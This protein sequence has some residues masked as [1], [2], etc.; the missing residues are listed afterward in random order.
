VKVRQ[1]LVIETACVL[2]GHDTQDD[3]HSGERLPK[4]G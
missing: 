1:H 4:V 3:V 2:G